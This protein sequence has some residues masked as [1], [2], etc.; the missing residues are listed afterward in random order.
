MCAG[1]S[2][3]SH[4]VC[5][6]FADIELYLVVSREAVFLGSR[7]NRVTRIAPWVEIAHP[8]AADNAGSHLLW[9]SSS[10]AGA[11]NR[12]AAQ[13]PVAVRRLTWVPSSLTAR[14]TR[15]SRSNSEHLALHVW[16][17]S[18]NVRSSSSQVAPRAPALTIAQSTLFL[19][20]SFCVRSLAATLSGF[21]PW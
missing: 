3:A 15:P 2:V 21:P 16:C 4:L 20:R 18:V 14:E 17:F 6:F 13:E 7:A 19:S 5:G 8:G 10:C 1:F 12:T 9:K 11:K